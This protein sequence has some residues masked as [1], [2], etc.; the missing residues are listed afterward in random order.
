MSPGHPMFLERIEERMAKV[1]A[2]LARVLT[3]LG[4][5]TLT[6]DNCPDFGRGAGNHCSWCGRRF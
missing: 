3:K 2:M 6:H 4:M 5:S 1:E